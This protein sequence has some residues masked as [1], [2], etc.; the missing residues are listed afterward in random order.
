MI[1][2]ELMATLGTGSRGF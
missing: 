1:E 2:T